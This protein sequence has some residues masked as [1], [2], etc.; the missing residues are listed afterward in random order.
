MYIKALDA[1]S[2]NCFTTP[3][4]L[5]LSLIHIWLISFQP[6]TEEW[7]L[8]QFLAEHNCDEEEQELLK[9]FSAFAESKA[10]LIHFNGNS[11]DIP[12]L[13]SRYEK[14]RL[15]NPLSCKNSLDL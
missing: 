7:Q 14:H 3:D 8:I 15:S 9:A 5:N 10:Q 11:F 1:V 12:Y 4:S 13:V 2:V 6:N